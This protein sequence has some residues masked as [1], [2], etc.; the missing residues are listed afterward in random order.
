M[1]FMGMVIGTIFIVLLITLAFLMLT[2]F[3]L[4][5]ILKNIGRKKDNKKMKTAGNVFLVLG[6]LFAVPIL[7]LIIY[8]AFHA[9]FTAV[10]LPNGEEKYVLARHISAMDS[11][12]EN[13]D[14]DSLH[15]LE[16]LLDK[17]S[18][19]VFYHDVNRESIL[20]DGL[21]TGNADI[22]R[23]AL[24]H[25]AIFDNPERYDHMAYVASSMDS[26]LGSCISH[27]IT[28][29]DIEIVEMMFEKN[30]STEL[31]E[32]TGYYSNVFGKAVWA[33]LYNDEAVTDIELELIQMFVDHGLSSDPELLLLEEV[34]S[35]YYFGPEYYANADSAAGSSNYN[36]LMDMIG[37][38]HTTSKRKG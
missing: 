12:V 13:P 24:E 36:Q 19:L 20:D 6:I 21:E 27:S 22:V 38:K 8:F 29:D 34:P 15:A 14:E 17:N 23:I 10:A 11:Y 9:I 2:F 31:K 3:V 32:S 35:N 33:V 5:A 1:A 7:A 28:E 30:A 37:K 16:K 4:S 25:G 26:Y 18:S